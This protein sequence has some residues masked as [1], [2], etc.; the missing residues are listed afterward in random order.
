MVVCEHPVP[1]SKEL[2]LLVVSHVT[3]MIKTEG[4]IPI[5]TQKGHLAY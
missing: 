4:E 5:K 3:T 2:V 1:D